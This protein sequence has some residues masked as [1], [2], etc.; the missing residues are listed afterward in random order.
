MTKSN[1]KQLCTSLT[2][3]LCHDVAMINLEK[4]KRCCSLYQKKK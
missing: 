2:I 4:N 3:S 1:F